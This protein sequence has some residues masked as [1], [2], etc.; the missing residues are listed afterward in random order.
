MIF[1]QQKQKKEEKR[2][3]SSEATRKKTINRNNVNFLFFFYF[4]TITHF[5]VNTMKN[6]KRIISPAT[7]VIWYDALAFYFI[8]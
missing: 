2:D 4:S 1:H 5:L 3:L 6:M 7:H 8:L